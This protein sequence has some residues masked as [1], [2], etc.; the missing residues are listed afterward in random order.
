MGLC[1]S[2]PMN[3][4]PS[5]DARQLSVK[6]RHIATELRRARVLDLK[7]E[8]FAR[9]L[10]AHA[11]AMLDPERSPDYRLFAQDARLARHG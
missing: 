2:I 7:T 11:T 5:F 4:T 9:Q 8:Q 3:A 6:L 1:L 10:E